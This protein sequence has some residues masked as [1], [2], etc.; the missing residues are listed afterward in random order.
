ME[1]VYWVVCRTHG[2]LSSQNKCKNK[3][4]YEIFSARLIRQVEDPKKD[5]KIKTKSF[6]LK[7]I[8]NPC[9]TSTFNG[10]NENLSLRTKVCGGQTV[11]KI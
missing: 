9:R 2:L 5:Q 11:R 6:Y 4:P 7:K 3:K 10:K 1:C 8:F